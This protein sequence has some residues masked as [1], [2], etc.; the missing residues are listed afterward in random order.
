MISAATPV[1]ARDPV[2]SFPVDCAL[3]KDCFI[4]NYVDA[5]P[6]KGAADF[7]CGALSNDGHT[8]TDIALISDVAAQAGVDVRPV[9]PG[10]VRRVRVGTK[11]QFLSASFEHLHGQ[12]CGNGVVVDHGGGWESQY[13]HLRN[14]S[15]TV[16]IGQRVGL[17]TTLGQ[18]G[19]SGRTEFPH[20]HLSVRKDGQVVDPFNADPLTYC[21]GDDARSLWADKIDYLPSGFVNAGFG[22]QLPDF[23]KVK[24]GQAHHRQINIGDGALVFWA[25]LFGAQTGDL[26]RL[27]IHGPM[28]TFHDHEE[29]LDATQARAM[30]A[31]GRLLHNGNTQPGHYQGIASLMRGGH[32]ID[33]I[34]ITT[35]LTAP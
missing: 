22:F 2:L 27:V 23:D 19:M 15:V 13:C 8:G 10:V 32:E 26:M 17:Q 25:Q 21:G 28:G 9:A 29:V 7:T 14:S 34:T 4:Q 11:D 12:D 35:T 3:G 24:W 33:R 16:E 6:S 31:A 18:I 5:D 30:R 20:L 1:A